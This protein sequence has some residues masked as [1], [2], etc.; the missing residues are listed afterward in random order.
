V[1]V[2]VGGRHSL[3]LTA[4]GDVWSWGWGGFGTLGHGD[5][6][7]HQLLPKKIEAFAGLRV[8][9]VAAG[10]GHSLALAADGSV[11]SWG[12]GGDGQLGHGDTQDQLLPKRIEA[13]AGQR[14][15]AVSAE[16]HSLATTADGAVW[17]WGGGGYGKLGHGDTQRQ[18]LPKK[19]EAF[20][21]QRVVAVSAGFEH[22]LA[23]T[24]DGSAWSWGSGAF[25]RLGHDDE[26]RQPLPK[27]VEALA[28]RGVVAVSAGGLHSLAITANGAVWSWGYGHCGELGHGDEQHQLLPKKVEA[29]A[30]QRVVA[31]SAGGCHSLALAADGAVY[32]WGLGETGRLG[33]GEDLSKQLL[34]KKIE[35]WSPGQ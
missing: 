25:G 35:V 16:D 12:F 10:A 27:K 28:G 8:A 29:F 34:P 1:S 14:V 11:W 4:D 33:H 22:S 15:V 6:Q 5:Q 26:Q 18:L 30:S 31:V 21:G 13:F 3:A 9:A 19:I 23:I 17:S 24:A 2:S 7:N 32:A 20:T